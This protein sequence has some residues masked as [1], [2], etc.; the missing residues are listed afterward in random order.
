MDRHQ[1]LYWK[2]RN[3]GF[4]YQMKKL[5]RILIVHSL[6]D[7]FRHKSFFLLIF[8]LILADRGLKLLKNVYSFDLEMPSLKSIN[9]DTAIYV[10]DTLPGT[11]LK[12]LS[13]YRLFVVL[14][15]LFLLKQI[16]SL[17]PSS[18]MRRMHRQERGTFGILA[19]LGAIRWDQLVWDAIAVST[20]CLTAIVWCGVW[21][22]IFR[23]CWHQTAA[24]MWLPVLGL[25][26][27]IIMPTVLAGFSYSSKLAVISQGTFGEKLALFYKLFTNPKVA[28][29]SWLFYA[30][31]IALEAVF[32]AAIP[33]YILLTVDNFFLRI[34]SAAVLATPVYSYLKMASFKFF[35]V[36][37]EP[38]GLVRQ[39]YEDYYQRLG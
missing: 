1:L 16:I 30:V 10:F 5:L 32:V 34:L 12:L 25:F 24:L 35:L 23:A 39:E 9:A 4:E 21:F 2:T 8:I 6:T 27:S 36:V 28:L 18:D 15:G 20:L 26:M 11:V 19:S 31:R 38:F 3:S 22:V 7:L 37:Y 13:D 17:W 33:A 29:W 14:A